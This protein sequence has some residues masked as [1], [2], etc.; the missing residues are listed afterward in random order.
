MPHG[1]ANLLALDGGEGK[2]RA[3][4]RASSKEYR[5]LMLKRS[6]LPGSSLGRVF[7][8]DMWGEDCRMHDFL[9]IGWT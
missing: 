6:K 5:Q 9:L 3:Y 2:A 1:K 8:D 4:L 7:K